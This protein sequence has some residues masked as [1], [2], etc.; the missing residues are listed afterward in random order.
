MTN[1]LSATVKE[2]EVLE[3][4]RELRENCRKNTIKLFYAGSKQH[5]KAG[6]LPDRVVVQ[7]YNYHERP[8]MK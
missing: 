3:A 4:I 7:A 6:V 1:I 8:D 5:T 2:E